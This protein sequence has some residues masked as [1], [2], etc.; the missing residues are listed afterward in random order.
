[1]GLTHF[2]EA[3]SNEFEVGHI[4]G[5]W[6]YLGESAGCQTVGVRRIQL[7]KIL[8]GGVGLVARLEKLD[9]WDGED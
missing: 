7:N 8:F 2:D 9:Y 3:H 5:T 4:R 1:M 6:S